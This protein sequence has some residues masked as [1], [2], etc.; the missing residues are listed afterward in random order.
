M[1]SK[2]KGNLESQKRIFEQAVLERTQLLKNAGLDEGTIMK[3]RRVK[4]LKGKV[5]QMKRRLST[6]AEIAQKYE[7]IKNRDKKPVEKKPERSPKKKRV[8]YA[9]DVRVE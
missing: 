3:D 9:D 2:T 5:R 8:E 7:A 4:F 6:I 1:S